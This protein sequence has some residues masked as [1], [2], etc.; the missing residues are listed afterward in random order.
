MRAVTAS[1]LASSLH[2]LLDGARAA[3]HDDGARPDQLLDSEAADEPN[4]RV[5]LRLRAT[6]LDDDRL[7]SNV[8]HAPAGQL[9]ELED[10]APVALGHAELD[11]GEL[12]LD[13]RLRGDVLDLEDIDQ[14]VELLRR[15][16]D[17][18]VVA[19]EADRHPREALAIRPAH[20]ERI[21]VE[22]PGAHQAGHPVQHAR[23]VDHDRHE[24][25]ESLLTAAGQ[26]SWGR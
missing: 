25:V 8:E 1:T 13:R 16:L 14:A 18:D 24:P 12:M 4:E 10:L 7:G 19:V 23:P 9:H 15:L 17:G 20:R 5:D 3:R 21:D 22:V 11:Q 6:D 2:R 26:G